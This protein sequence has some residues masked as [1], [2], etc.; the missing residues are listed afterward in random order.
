MIIQ[1]RD[2]IE[3]EKLENSHG[4]KGKYEVRTLFD[5]GFDS[6]MSYIREVVLHSGSTIGIHPHEG[7]EEIYYV[8][9]GEGEMIVDD[10]TRPVKPGDTVL[11]KSGSRHGL[12]NTSNQDLK[13]FVVCARVA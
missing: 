9:S 3:N 8:I 10:E 2:T 4:G 7:D 6:S 13:I 1:G 11:T 5:S 12:I